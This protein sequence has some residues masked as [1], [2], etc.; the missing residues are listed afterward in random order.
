MI[1]VNIDNTLP[2]IGECILVETKHCK[3]N[4]QTA[5]YN[6]LNFLSTDD[7]TIIK[8][9]E[10]WGYINHKVNV[11]SKDQTC[12]KCRTSNYVKTS[13]L[14]EN[15]HCLRCDNVWHK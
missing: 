13:V 7:K 3:Y 1:W 11:S 4:F 2:K 15:W 14:C 8:N 6:G 10:Y 12:P 5:I 9:I